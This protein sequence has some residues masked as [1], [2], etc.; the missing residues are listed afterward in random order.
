MTL[1]E[2]KGLNKWHVLYNLINQDIINLCHTIKQSKSINMTSSTYLYMNKE[3]K[4]C[5]IF[6][7]ISERAPNLSELT[8]II[9]NMELT[10]LD[11][12][13]STYELWKH[14]YYYK[15]NLI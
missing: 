8:L 2:L 7:E 1:N 14:H 5:I 9:F 12:E 4:G 13:V 10:H 6:F 3:Y 11:S 15:S